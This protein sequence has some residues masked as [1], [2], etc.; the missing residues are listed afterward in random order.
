MA[1]NLSGISTYWEQPY[2][3]QSDGDMS[4]HS[5]IDMMAL[6]A[7]LPPDIHHP[8]LATAGASINT[9]DP[10]H[11]Y[12][13][14][15]TGADY[16]E[17]DRV[18][19][20]SGAQPISGSLTPNRH[21]DRSR[22]SFQTVSSVDNSPARNR[23]TGRSLGQDLSANFGGP[24]QR[25]YGASLNPHEYRRSR[26]PTGALSRAGS[27]VRAMSQRV[28]NLSG[29]NE[30]VDNRASRHR[31]QSPHA[32]DRNTSRDTAASML[33]DTSYQPQVVHPS[34]EKTG[35]PRYLITES[36]PST[37]PRPPLPN[38]LKGKSL[39]IFSPDNFL[40][41]RLCDL[42]VNPYTEPFL[43]LLIVLQTILLAVDAAPPISADGQGRP[44]HWKGS[45]IDW[46]M[47][48]LFI[49]FTFEL[50]SRIIVSGFIL[51]AAEFST[52]D[53]KRGIRAAVADQ[54]RV[55]FQPERQKSVKNKH[56][57]Q[58]EPSTIAR[59][60]TTFMQGQ[61]AMPQT[62]EEQQ[63]FQLARRAFLR[64]SFNRIDF[65]AVV[66]FWI[67]FFLSATGLETKH[68]LYVFRMMS[69]L[70]ILR[71]LALT[72][73]TAIILRSLK[74]A[75]PLLVRVAF[76]LSFF[77]LLFA[78]IGVQ[79]F[80]AS[81][82]RQCVWL[83]PLDPTNIDTSYTVSESF[84]GGFLDNDT[85]KSMPW[86]MFSSP[87]SLVNLIEGST[88]GKGFLCPRGSICL[89]QTNPFGGTVNFDNIF[90]SLELVFVIMSANTFSDL[91]Y[92]TMGSDYS[93]A[94]LFFGAGI[95]IMMLWLTNLVI[96]VITSSFQVIREE[97][98]AS[99]FTVD[100]EPFAQPR[101]EERL[102]RA[103][104][105]RV[106]DRTAPIWVV[107]IAFGLLCQACRSSTMSQSRETF[108][109]T[110]E[111]VVTIL[112]DVEMMI[113]IITDWHHF[114][115]S[116]R[117][118]LDLVLAVITSIILIPP[119]RGTR[120]YDWLTIFQ[121]VRVYRVVLAIP[122]TRQLIQLVLGNATG[123]A[124]L[125]FFVFLMTFMMAIFAVQLF[126]GEIPVHDDGELNRISFYQI[127]N[128]FIGM[129]Q[130]LSSENWTAILYTVTSYTRPFNTSWIGA[131]LL[132][133][134][135]I[136]AFFILVNMFIA[137]IQ[138]NFDV[139]EDEKRLQQVKA[140]LQR[141]DLGTPSSHLAL[142]T[143]FTFGKSRRHKDPLDYGP[144]TMEML[145]KDAVVRE[146]LD[147]KMDTI[148]EEADPRRPLPRSTTTLLGNDVKPGFM[149]GV[150]GNIVKRLT[151]REPNPFYSN[152]RFDSPN[153]TQDPRQMA[154]QAVSATSARR[155]AQREY[156][157]RYPTYNNSLYI[158]KPDNQIRKLCQRVVGPARGPERFDG[159]EPNRVAWYTFTMFIYAC[160][161]AMVVLACVTTP[162]YQKEYQE[163]HE[164]SIQNW[165]IWTDM[166]FAAVFTIEAGI[167]TIADGLI[168]TPNA[169]LRSSWGLM[170]AVVLITLWI[171][172]VT[173]LINDGAISR[174]IGAFKA[175]RA[176]RL[177]NVSNSARNT[178]HDLIIVGWWKIL[179][180]AF[181]SLSLLIPFAIYGLNLF[182]GLMQ[183]CNDGGGGISTMSDC[184]GEYDSTPFSDDWPM[185]APR[186]ATN[187]YFNFDD[188]G[189][190]LFILFQIVSQEGWIDVS[191]ASQAIT[192]RN[193]QPS[194]LASQGNALFFVAF[195][196]LATVFVL[197][198]FISVFM[199]NYTEQTGVA[200]L[201]AEQRS[202][203]ELR[204][205]LRQISPSKSS[206]DD[207]EKSWKKWC[208][209]RAIEKRGKWYQ[210]ITFVLVLHLG[211]L[212]SEFS[213]EPIWWTSTR[214]FVFF[215]FILIY[216]TNIAIRILG[217]GW[218]RFRRS[219]W[220]IYSL[221][222]VG[223]A[224]IATLSLLISSTNIEVYVQLHKV[225]LV[226]IVLLLIPRNDAL[227]QLFKTA[228]ASLTVIGNLL[229]TWLVIFLVFAIAL[230][231]AFSLTRFGGSE[232]N[233]VNFRTVPK[234]LILLFRMSLG[235]GW[236]QLMEDYA[237]IEPPLCVEES[238]FFDSDCGS[239]SWARFLFIAWNIVS[240]YIFVNLFVSLIYESFSYVYQRS[241][242][243]AVVD[244]DEIRRFKEAWRSVDP[245]GTGYITKDAFPR[246]L[247]ELS[248]V[249]QMRIY[250]SDDSVRS[251]LED[252]QN[253]AKTSRHMS[254]GTT[255]ASAGVDLDKLNQRIA[256]LDVVK[257]R[258]RRRRFNVFY[259]EI[260]VSADPD[261]GIS[262]TTVL[263]ILAHYNII[264]DNKSLKLEEFLRRR[265]RLQR[266]EEQVR[267]R[268]V[269]GFFDT[270]YWSRKFKQHLQ[271]KQ[272]SRM[273]AIPHL[274]IP[275]IL[276]ED[277][278]SQDGT[279]GGAAPR[280][281]IGQSSAHSSVDGGQ[282]QSWFGATDLSLHDTAWHHPL[283]FPRGAPP[284][285]SHHATP[286]AFSFELQDPDEHE[287][288]AAV[289]NTEPTTAVSPSQ[290]RGMLDDSV[291][292]ESIR[293]SATVRR[294]QQT[295]QYRY[296]DLE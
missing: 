14:D 26:S 146:F 209:K 239:K 133:G 73:G 189:S 89:Q 43:L 231:Q 78:I 188:F 13:E 139:S 57:F 122:V 215:A 229:A 166:A 152:L 74:K 25:S 148:N 145:L 250:D 219:S 222:I 76:L 94:A 179:G 205:I 12:I 105:Q 30:I 99:A 285:T 132:I 216:M 125:M 242:G 54:Y 224:F 153:D 79:S 183:T 151:H 87:N 170:D 238:R 271:M 147:D 206:Y 91:M 106:Y 45:A 93:Q 211:V 63:R 17:S 8:G 270:L 138:E 22:D 272:A 1:A 232:T 38:P 142:S 120:A 264:S 23:D 49:I 292:V 164:F 160:I 207:S 102:R 217:L 158:F 51:N 24:R 182:N 201:T 144:A 115:S 193:Q 19:L 287:H 185:L 173:L 279:T 84:C 230:T 104:L 126:R 237:N 223:G 113:R 191:F 123:I 150:W 48:V 169:F 291:W 268:I 59:S 210:T 202:W 86:V 80:K 50:I 4:P 233:D 109:N 124:N 241:S 248:G 97:S 246:L 95:M 280:S 137:V 58:A 293:R 274:D 156:L 47:L 235:E 90:N 186:V 290:V 172:V 62:L 192:G 116:W 118:I 251:I 134:W 127:F 107:I 34:A 214:D 60:F 281:P 56:Q 101:A 31:S 289:D 194:D 28:V 167:K 220:D 275:D 244:R 100:Q 81:L 240:M 117:N 70:R 284:S 121:I 265:A 282:H 288:S 69:C 77:W 161:V 283:S 176:L 221:L 140:F 168:W 276:V 204:K 177:L 75:A 236:N 195:N 36:A 64:H 119:I 203:L 33:V 199:R 83:D 15:A 53:R 234:A 155:R 5:P 92:Y 267:R 98:K 196:L 40:R 114:H 212:V 252:V 108:I 37:A 42:L 273:T 159:L 174:A 165:Y 143:I 261:R 10:P 157:A 72:N 52:I 32:F 29:E 262:F 198:L 296:G 16:V 228:A 154:Q 190:S 218:A 131:I 2:H 180:A 256:E 71:L 18:P 175:L 208:H 141:R 27:I 6:Q 258:E 11:P 9:F 277:D 103:P 184:F 65:V 163:Q 254:I 257:I 266:V 260:M 295:G 294:S 96:A 278:E 269:L 249:F 136:V 255:T 44:E 162:L 178:F 225:F 39:G 66:S 130:V 245:A 55:I 247:G 226:G 41:R 88:E 253:D 20:T 149:S 263:M 171:N 21:D 259:E 35:E 82:R 111:V 67:M 227:D 112:L 46:A 110:A 61:Q 129:Y 85:G 243:M 200:F 181:V 128:S 213:D 3:T 135:F 197:T 7:A 68:H 286:S 187:P